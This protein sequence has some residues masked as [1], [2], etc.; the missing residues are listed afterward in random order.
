MITLE[1][2]FNKR[3][4][5]EETLPP[6]FTTMEL[7]GK[8]IKQQKHLKLCGKI[9]DLESIGKK[10]SIKKDGISIRQ[11]TINEDAIEVISGNEE[12]LK[13]PKELPIYYEEWF[14]DAG[15]YLFLWK[16][17]NEEKLLKLA[18]EYDEITIE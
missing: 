9:G 6:V 2:V 15:S 17:K 14:M 1:K 4:P 18:T 11:F 8:I 7:S 5:I 13:L 10:F 12:T 3:E 16:Y